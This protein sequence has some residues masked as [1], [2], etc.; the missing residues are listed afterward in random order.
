MKEMTSLK[1]EEMLVFCFLLI[2]QNRDGLVTIE[3]LMNLLGIRSKNNDY[4][5][6]ITSDVLKIYAYVDRMKQR[7]DPI[8]DTC[9]R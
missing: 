1:R 6:L 5:P 9:D 7:G 4:N 8:T 3:D 2:D